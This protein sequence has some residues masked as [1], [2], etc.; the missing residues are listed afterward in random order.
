MGIE[1]NNTSQSTPG[2]WSQKDLEHILGR[3][4]T[5]IV[6]RSGTDIDNALSSLQQWKENIWVIQ[7][8]I[9]NDVS[10]TKIRLL[11]RRGMSVRYL[12]PSPGITYIKENGLYEEE[13][14]E[15]E[16]DASN[17]VGEKE[18]EKGKARS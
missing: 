11:L 9:Q 8:I 18:K 5:F 1:T 15:K 12:M 16:K 13:G 3:Y 7:Q 4:G 6:E 14:K 10:S 17:S 2:V